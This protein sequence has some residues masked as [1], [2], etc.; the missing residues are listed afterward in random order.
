MFNNLKDYLRGTASLEVDASGETTQRDLQ[1]ATTSLLLYMA[2]IDNRLHEGERRQMVGSLNRQFG[3]SDSEAGDLLEVADYLIED[4]T[5]LDTL[6]RKVKESFT[7][8]QKITVLA[9][10]YKV[11]IG[12]GSIS[13]PEVWLASHITESFGLGAERFQEAKKLVESGEV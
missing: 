8:S 4:K 1:I 5:K 3:L 9:L 7:E 12:D 6:I 11:M 10:L 13:D 2:S